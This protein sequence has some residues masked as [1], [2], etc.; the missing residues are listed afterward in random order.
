MSIPI[1][2]TTTTTS[3]G[4]MPLGPEQQMGKQQ[5]DQ[6]MGGQQFGQQ[7]Q[8]QFDQSSMMGGGGQRFDQPQMEGQRFD[9]GAQQQQ[10]F[11]QQQF[12]QP[13]QFGGGQ[14]QQF[15]QPSMA[16]QGQQFDQPSMGGQFGKT[17]Q[18]LQQPM[19]GGQ[20]FQDQSLQTGGLQGAY[21][22][23]SLAPLQQGPEEL[24]VQ[25][26]TGEQRRFQLPMGGPA[27]IPGARVK[28][29]T[30]VE[31]VP[32]SDFSVP[33]GF[34]VVQYER[35]IEVD[36]ANLTPT[37]ILTS[38]PTCT[39]VCTPIVCKPEIRVETTTIPPLQLDTKTKE[40][41]GGEEVVSKG[42]HGEKIRTIVTQLPGGGERIET[43]VKEPLNT[44]IT[45]REDIKTTTTI[46][47]CGPLGGVTTVESH[48][49]LVPPGTY[50]QGGYGAQGAQG[51]PRKAK[52]H[53]QGLLGSLRGAFSR[54]K[55]GETI[56]PK[57]T[58]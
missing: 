28:E 55:H 26:P 41:P 21:P 57:E 39:E 34:K 23:Q 49:H 5:F 22:L 1:R 53:E 27:A 13:S 14:G 11:G 6:P 35:D 2:D 8:Q 50:A 19:M 48:S 17:E 42:P 54:G 43:K 58:L 30:V 33:P 3:T 18:G 47:E 16:G 51:A 37:P 24:S 32:L 20:G 52:H 9:Q 12:E 38:I 10:Q 4:Q 15:E 45:Q 44:G 36:L 56:P 40:F 25:F 46:K 29:W 7:Q 31:S